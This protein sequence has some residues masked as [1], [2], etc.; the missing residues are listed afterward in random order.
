MAHGLS[1]ILESIKEINENIHFFIGGGAYKNKLLEKAKKLSLKNCTFLD[2][3]PKS[4]IKKYISITDI[5]LVNLKKSKTFKSVI[6]SK[7]F[8]NAAMR[9]PILLGVEGESALIINSYGAGECFKPEDE[10]DFLKNLNKIYRKKILD[11]NSYC[12]GLERL[13]TDFNRQTLAKQM[14]DLIKPLKT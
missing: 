2:F 7:I 3:V 6:P 10:K 11:N 1:F 14:L 9:K 13:A 8:E 12:D 5:A 4:E